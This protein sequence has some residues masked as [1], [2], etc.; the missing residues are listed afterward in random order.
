ME[1]E[2]LGKEL[3]ENPQ[4]WR[5]SMKISDKELEMVVYNPT[6][7]S[8]FMYHRLP[9]AD[10]STSPIA[11]LGDAVYDNTLLLSEFAITDVLIDTPRFIIAPAEMC[12]EGMDNA[13]ISAIWPN[14]KLSV[15]S[16]P[17][18]GSVD[19]MLAGVDTKV[20]SFIR[21]TFPTATVRHRLVPLL[22]YLITNDHEVGTITMYVNVRE[23]RIDVIYFNEHG[24]YAVNTYDT[25][26][27]EDMLYYIMNTAKGC[28]MNI[29][30]DEMVICGEPEEAERLRSFIR[31]Y[32]RTVLTMD[33]PYEVAALG[34]GALVAPLELTLLPLC[35]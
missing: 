8:T 26:T 32:A 22:S 2:K 21:R 11:A 7:Q 10:T 29:N 20:I 3:V 27:P 25:P 1:N 23:N 18:V 31:K 35:V 16:Y 12:A 34:T 4:D 15:V 14:E 17:I 6:Q 24:L 33:P 9:L 28:N 30:K 13:I 19:T 5:L